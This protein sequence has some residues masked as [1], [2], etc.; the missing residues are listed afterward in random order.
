MSESIVGVRQRGY[1]KKAS[2]AAGLELV[3]VSSAKDESLGVGNDS[4]AY[5]TSQLIGRQR[6]NSVLVLITLLA[7]LTRFY[8]L[9]HPDEVVFDE[10]HFGKVSYI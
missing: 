10:V 2:S 3:S 6:H 4:S 9:G 8:N 5:G 7:F 1:K